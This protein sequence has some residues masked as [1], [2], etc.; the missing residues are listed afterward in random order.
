V[1]VFWVLIPEMKLLLESWLLDRAA[2]MSEGQCR[3]ALSTRSCDA[4][5]D[6]KKKSASN[7]CMPFQTV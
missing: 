7:S 6:Q 3:G 5:P 2:D 4:E 1:I